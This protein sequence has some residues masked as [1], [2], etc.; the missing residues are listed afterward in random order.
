MGSYYDIVEGNLRTG[1]TAKSSDINHI[2]V[3][4]QDAIKKAISDHHNGESYLL[5]A[6]DA[7]KNDFILTPAPKFLSA[8]HLPPF[9]ADASPTQWF[10]EEQEAKSE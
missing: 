10:E 4:V 3:H 7:H 2:Q 1:D 5:G 6:G 9:F 8:L